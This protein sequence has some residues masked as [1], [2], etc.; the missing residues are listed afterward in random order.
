LAH[1]E[2]FIRPANSGLDLD[3]GRLPTDCTVVRKNVAAN[4]LAATPTINSHYPGIDLPALDYSPVFNG[5]S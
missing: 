3:Q 1:C 2:G 5:A 4:W